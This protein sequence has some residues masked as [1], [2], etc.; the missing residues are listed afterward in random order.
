MVLLSENG[1]SQGQNLASTVLFVPNSLYSEG[2]HIYRIN[3]LG[4]TTSDLGKQNL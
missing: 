3:S 1:S 2:P 4:L